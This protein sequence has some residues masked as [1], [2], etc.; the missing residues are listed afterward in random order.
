MAFFLAMR[1]EEQRN[2]RRQLKD[3]QRKRQPSKAST[4]IT[5]PRGLY[6]ECANCSANAEPM[7]R[8]MQMQA[9]TERKMMC[10]L[11]KCINKQDDETRRREDC[12]SPSWKKHSEEMALAP[13]SCR[14]RCIKEWQPGR[15]ESLL[16]KWRKRKTKSML[17]MCKSWAPVSIP[18]QWSCMA[19]LIRRRL[20]FYD[21]SKV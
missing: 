4:M 9:L 8:D 11:A 12:T 6:A 14:I 10:E 18:F 19:R 21:C 2:S 16:A 20:T 17:Q 7:V 5:I 13:P 1:G 15:L 3:R